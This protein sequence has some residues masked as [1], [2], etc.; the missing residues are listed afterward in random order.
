MC[1][2]NSFES[3]DIALDSC[4]LPITGQPI[5]TAHS[6]WFSNLTGRRTGLSFMMRCRLKRVSIMHEEY[7]RVGLQRSKVY[8][9]R[10]N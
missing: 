3:G 1:S 4:V 5:E 2:W 7:A 10:V 6:S 8:M 9:R